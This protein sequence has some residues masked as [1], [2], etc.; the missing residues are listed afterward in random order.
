MNTQHKHLTIWSRTWVLICVMLALAGCDDSEPGTGTEDTGTLDARSDSGESDSSTQDSTGGEDTTERDEGAETTGCT[1][2]GE[3]GVNEVCDAGTC[4]CA[5]GWNN[6]PEIGSGCTTDFS[7]LNNCGTSCEDWMSCYD[8]NRVEGL[9]CDA[10][11]CTFTGC[12][13]GYDNCLP[14]DMSDASTLGCETHTAADPVNCGGCGADFTCPTDRENVDTVGCQD[15][16]CVVDTCAENY[17]DCDGDLSNGCETLLNALD[18]CG[19]CGY[20]CDREDEI[21][22]GTPFEGLDPTEFTCENFTC[23][24]AS[25][26]SAGPVP[27]FSDC[28]GDPTNGC[29]AIVGDAFAEEL[30]EESFLPE[31]YVINASLYC[32]T[33]DSGCGL[34]ADC[35]AGTCTAI[36]QV[37]AGDDFTCALRAPSGFRDQTTWSSS[38]GFVACWGKNDKGQLGSGSTS[39]S[40]AA[41]VLVTDAETGTYLDG[42]IHISAGR[43]HACAVLSSGAVKC[44]GA[45]GP[46][47]GYSYSSDE[48]AAKS[49]G[50]LGGF[51]MKQVAAGM[52]HTCAAGDTAVF[53]WG[54][55]DKGQAGLELSAGTRFGTAQRVAPQNATAPIYPIRS[56]DAGDDHTCFIGTD[57]ANAPTSYPVYCWGD[58]TYKQIDDGSASVGANAPRMVY[59]RDFNA[60]R[61]LSLGANHT[62]VISTVY[63]IFSMLVRCWGDG[64]AGQLTSKQR[65]SPF[66]SIADESVAYDQSTMKVRAGGDNTCVAYSDGT[67]SCVGSNEGGILGYTPDGGTPTLTT[68]TTV[69]ADIDG[70]DVG[71]DHACYV[72]DSHVYCWGDNTNGQLGFSTTQSY[73]TTPMQVQGL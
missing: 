3:C 17:G 18:N 26:L 15:G 60:A 68:V 9:S 32:G 31:P 7:D 67:F 13:S 53:C 20:V 28:D 50:G 64:R 52:E 59:L 73:S 65:V 8:L 1:G 39:I 48:P 27:F 51:Q 22:A 56:I 43:E 2:D 63:D 42:V 10:G 6:C 29:E 66:T 49:V 23:E 34:G 55:N 30:G 54:M 5:E 45:A 25:C 40:E 14:D 70:V 46:W 24:V 21:F 58:N 33:C 71:V 11:A 72:Q 12:E 37:A 41:P 62:C 61:S 4:V 36:A 57:S 44:W 16:T 38:G 69:P 35:S 47:L 19:A